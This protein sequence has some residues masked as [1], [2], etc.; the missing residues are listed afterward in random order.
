MDLTGRI[1]I[2]DDSYRFI[3]DKYIFLGHGM[4]REGNFILWHSQL[5][6]AHNQMLQTLYESGLVG[7]ILFYYLIYISFNQLKFMNNKKY[8]LIL[9]AVLF[10]MLIMMITEIYGY[11]IPTYTLFILSYYSPKLNLKNVRDI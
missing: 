9:C 6:Q 1:N 4:P 11:Y 2:W 8:S 7:T 10:S 3:F 5:W